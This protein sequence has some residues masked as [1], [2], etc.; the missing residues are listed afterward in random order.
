MN[1]AKQETKQFK[2][3]PKSVIIDHYL[4][5]HPDCSD[6]TDSEVE[7]LRVGGPR[8]LKFHPQRSIDRSS[9]S[10]APGDDTSC[11][12]SVT[13]EFAKLTALPKNRFNIIVESDEED[14]PIL[15]CSEEYV[16]SSSC[17]AGQVVE[18]EEEDEAALAWLQGEGPA[19]SP[20]PSPKMKCDVS[21]MTIPRSL[22]ESLVN[23]FSDIFSESLD[24]N[25]SPTALPFQ[26][27]SDSE[28][29]GTTSRESSDVGYDGESEM[30]FGECASPGKVS[31]RFLTDTRRSDRRRMTSLA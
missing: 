30:D 25:L 16:Q 18:V 29:V 21:P 17:C 20:T 12:A 2:S 9:R 22:Q 24:G 14:D 1:S 7:K 28:S 13:P 31:R 3:K 8:P 26:G 6:R 10:T 4:D 5:D 27:Y 23:D 11:S 15:Q 19:P